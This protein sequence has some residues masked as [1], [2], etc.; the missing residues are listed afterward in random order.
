M[1][2]Y[3]YAQKT[4]LSGTGL[5]RTFMYP[6]QKQRPQIIPIYINVNDVT[7]N[8]VTSHTFVLSLFPRGSEMLCI[9]LRI[10]LIPI[11]MEKISTQLNIH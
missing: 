5:P 8:S 11:D 1:L 9:C 4:R 2:S 7:R 10:L 3:Y 6:E